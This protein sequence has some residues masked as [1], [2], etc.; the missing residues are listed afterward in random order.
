MWKA[1]AIL[2]KALFA[3]ACCFTVWQALSPPGGPGSLVPWDKAL[4]GGTFFVL[5]G[6][7]LLAFP[8]MKLWRV[9][10]LMLGFGGLIEILQSLPLFDRDAEWADMLADAVGIGAVIGVAVAVALRRKLPA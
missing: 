9:A 4:H 2:F 10:V 8:K 6:M 1:A 3:A 5:T 7:A